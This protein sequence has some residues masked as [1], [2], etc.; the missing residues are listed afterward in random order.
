MAKKSGKKNKEVGFSDKVPIGIIIGVLVLAL[1]LLSIQIPSS[2]EVTGSAVSSNF[3]SK[4]FGDWGQGDLDVSVA[5][6]LMFGV[7]I[8]LIFSIFNMT[9][10]PPKPGIQWILSILVS[11]L[12][13]AY[14]TPEEIFT[15]LTAYSALG[16]TLSIFVP[17]A[18][19]LLFS[20]AL[21]S[22]VKTT[23][24]GG[25]IKYVPGKASVGQIVIVKFLWL[26]FSGFLLYKLISGFGSPDVELSTGMVIVLLASFI[27]SI[28][29][30]IFNK[31]FREWIRKIGF[32]VLKSSQEGERIQAEGETEKAKQASKK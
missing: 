29:I 21:L 9:N 12:A 10:I 11:F 7:L 19:M 28:L 20:A 32:E 8:L 16:M 14:I 2:A 6:Y 17:F 13:V 5:K 15:I 4:M 23:K 24:G 18:V 1:L 31:N 25:G 22:T 26:L 3:I 27:A 30:A